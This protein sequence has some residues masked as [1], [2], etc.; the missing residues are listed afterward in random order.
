MQYLYYDTENT[1]KTREHLT[2]VIDGEQKGNLTSFLKIVVK[3][4]ATRLALIGLMTQ[5]NPDNSNTANEFL[6]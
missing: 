5:G 6:L 3:R 4:R 1:G 2:L